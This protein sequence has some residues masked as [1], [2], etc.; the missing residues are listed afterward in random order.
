MS[1]CVTLS[2]YHLYGLSKANSCLAILLVSLVSSFVICFQSYVLGEIQTW[3]L[4]ICLYLNLKHGK[5]D[6][7][8]TTAGNANISHD[9]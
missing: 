6:H 3:D 9:V 5:L 2:W 8:G 7:S 4:T 1:Y